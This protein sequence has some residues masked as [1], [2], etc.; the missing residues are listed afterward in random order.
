MD[1][2]E[3]CEIDAPVVANFHP[4]CSCDMPWKNCSIY[5]YL[6]GGT[7]RKEYIEGFTIF[8]LSRLT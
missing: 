6:N 7:K 4:S 3:E 2:V 8:F 1:I 5:Q